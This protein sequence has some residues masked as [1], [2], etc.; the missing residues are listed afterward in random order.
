MVTEVSELQPEKEALPIFVTPLGMVTEVSELQPQK[1]PSSISVTPSGM[2]TEVSE[3]QPQKAL[4]P[5]T[6]THPLWDGHRG[7]RSAFSKKVVLM[8]VIPSGRA[9][10]LSDVHP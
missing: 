4:S 5:I 8:F 7:Q 2:V 10:D 3:L 9:I 6:V 1:A